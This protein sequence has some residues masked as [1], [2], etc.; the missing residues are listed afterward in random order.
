MLSPPKQKK[1]KKKAWKSGIW[2]KQNEKG[3]SRQDQV[4]DNAEASLSVSMAEN[5]LK[6]WLKWW[7]RAI[8]SL[9]LLRN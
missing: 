5:P 7:I 2:K 9:S 4:P 1:T 6:A 3:G 8:L